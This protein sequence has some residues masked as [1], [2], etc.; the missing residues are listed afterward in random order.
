[1]NK[2]I[3][4]T[5]TL[6]YCNDQYAIKAVVCCGFERSIVILQKRPVKAD[7]PLMG[8]TIS[9]NDSEYRFISEPL[10]MDEYEKKLDMILEGVPSPSI[11]SMMYAMA[12]GLCLASFQSQE[13]KDV[14]IPQT[15]V[16]LVKERTHP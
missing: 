16:A 13:A 8:A 15:R 4:N 7:T 6:E 14:E 3:F 11:P 1:M 2:L 10:T 9:Y 12:S 5:D